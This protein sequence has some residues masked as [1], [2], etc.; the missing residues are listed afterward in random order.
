MNC[1]PLLQG[2]AASTWKSLVRDLGRIIAN[3]EPTLVVALIK[4]GSS[5]GSLVHH[6]R[7]GRGAVLYGFNNGVDVS[8]HG[9]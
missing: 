7:I 5:S 4:F 2:D 6:D 3:V 9:S 1:S 8:L